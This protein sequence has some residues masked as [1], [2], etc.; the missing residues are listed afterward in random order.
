MISFDF[1]ALNFS[2]PEKNRY[3]Y[4]LNGFDFDWIHAG[5]RQTAT[6]TNLDGGEYSFHVVAANN[7]GIWN[8]EGASVAIIISPPYW[9]TWWFY[10]LVTVF[11]ALLPYFI[12]KVR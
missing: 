4:K 12:Y 9:K 6:Y 1:A 7:D 3:A 11:I 10:A 5:N 2:N 8:L